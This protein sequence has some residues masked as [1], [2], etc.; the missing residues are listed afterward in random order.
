MKVLIK[1]LLLLLLPFFTLAQKS[2]VFRIDSLPQ[3]GITLNKNWKFHAGDNPDFAKPDFDDSAWESIDPSLDVFELQQIPKNGQI[4]W[5]RLHLSVDSTLNKQLALMIEQSGASKI[6]LNGI[7]MNQFGILSTIPQEIKAFNPNEKPIPI[8]FTANTAQ[9][10]SVRYALQPKIIYATHFGS[11]NRILSIRLISAQVAFE[12]YEA[13]LN[14]QNQWNSFAIGMNLVLFILYFA[15]YLYYSKRKANLYF[16]GYALFS[17]ILNTVSLYRSYINEVEAFFWTKNLDLTTGVIAALFLLTAVYHLFNAKKSIIFWSLIGLGFLSILMAATIYG[18]G[19]LIYSLPF[20]ILNRLEIL[21]ISVL[22]MNRKIK[23]ARIILIGAMIS[24]IFFCIFT[25]SV[26]NH[27]Y[28]NIVSYSFTLA[29]IGIPLAV[30]IYLGYDFALT[31]RTLQQKFSENEK[32]SKEKQQ[33]LST[34]NETLEKQVTE[35]T[36]E[37]VSKNRDLEIEGSLERVRARAMAMQNSNE[38][39]KLVDL[40]FKELTKLHFSLDRCLILII[41]EKTV[42][43]QQWL[44]NP[45]IDQTPLSYKVPLQEVD[46]FKSI[47]NAWQQR[48]N[49]HIYKLS[50][51]PKDESL[52]YLFGKT[53]MKLLPDAV[54]EG[55]KATKQIFLNSSFSNF[56]SIQADTIEPLSEE[57]LDILSRF[58]KVF[59]QT[60]TRFLDLQKAEAQAREAEIELALERV[61]SRTMAMQH[62][63]ELAEAANLLFQ[64][65]HALGIPAWSCGFNIWEK[66]DKSCTGWMSSNGILQPSFKIPLTES[67]SFIRQ[68]ESK[69]NGEI[70]YVEEVSGEALADHYRY[71]GS[72]P[73]FGEILKDFTKNG[74]VLPTFQIN[75]GVNFKHGTLVFIT[76]EPVP[77]SWDIFNRLAKVFEQTYTRFLDLKKAEIQAREAQLEAAFERIRSRA[78]AM[79]GSDEI[80]VLIGYIY[81]EC[82]RLEMNL[83]RSLLMTFD[84]NTHDSRWWLGAPEVSDLPMSCFVQYHEYA[85]SLAILKGWLDR[86]QKWVYLLEGENKKTWDSYLFEKTGLVELPDPVKQ[87]MRSVESIILNASFQNFGCVMLASYEQLNDEHFN[88]LVRLSKVFDLAYTRYLDLQLKEE[89]AIKLLHEKQKLEKTLTELKATQAQLIQSEKLASLGELTAG[90]AHEIQNPMNFV[91]NFAKFN[92]GIADELDEEINKPHID[93]EYIAELLTDLKSN[94]EKIN[95]HGNRASSI[96]SGMLEHSRTRTAEKGLTDINKLCDEYF[97]LSFHA[98][99]NKDKNFNCDMI[100]HFDASI[101]EIEIVGP[102]VGRVVLNLINNAFYAVNERAVNLVGFKNLRGLGENLR[103]Y[104]PTVS[105]ITQKTADAIEIRVKDNGT[106]MSENVKAKIFQPF[107]TTKP[108]GSGTGL[109]L[110]LAYDIITKGHGGSLKVESEEGVGSEFII[111]LQVT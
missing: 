29:Q 89:N 16:S 6:Y 5:L 61:R 27:S 77:E 80:N 92:M 64:Q 28:L 87:G 95:F 58:A 98:L 15:F 96:V 59:D 70:F 24:L 83:N 39:S 37:L 76:S 2:D 75:H 52:E 10:L 9:V 45:E 103:G 49:K 3:E 105:V 46:V 84:K 30:A 51:A 65:V 66:N 102:D 22:A 85:P 19:W 79:S 43:A 11:N 36:A 44:A 82:F 111:S 93:K 35:R 34:Q 40:I 72:L 54:K 32:L 47:F 21:R 33:I 14:L 20:N 23:G 97:R 62:S 8:T 12:I 71:M 25:I 38:L 55:F 100:T 67:P 106:G 73:D 110:S 31:N 48:L 94:Q 86:E 69:Q 104:K 108:T 13:S 26:S 101:P 91:N 53:E 4:I 50:G 60:Y 107:F 81:K 42:S 88:L 90:I 78:M 18:W 109:G 17:C 63:D 99:R 57:N 56:G 41:D 74:Y 1:T 7:L 68:Y